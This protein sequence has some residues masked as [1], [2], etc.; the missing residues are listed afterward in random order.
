M[1]RK[2]DP[3]DDCTTDVLVAVEDDYRNILPEASKRLARFRS[4]R[5]AN[6]AATVGV[7]PTSGPTIR[8][9]E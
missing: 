4:Q 5:R 8:R 6:G 9:F 7:V 2:Q 3:K 1:S